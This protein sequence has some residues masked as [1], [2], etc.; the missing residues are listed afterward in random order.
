MGITFHPNGK[1]EGLN[2]ANYHESFTAGQIIQAGV[3]E[4]SPTFKATS[5]SFSANTT[6]TSAATYS[7]TGG[8]WT[9]T[10]KST[11]SK[12]IGLFS[13]HVD[14]YNH[15]S[16][17]PSIIAI[18]EGV[19]SRTAVFG[20]AYRHIRVS[21]DEPLSWI[22]GWVD[23]FSTQTNSAVPAYSVRCHSSGDGLGFGTRND[24]STRHWPCKVLYWEVAV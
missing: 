1:I 11:S 18:T 15:S 14:A 2:N 13:G 24:G 3:H 20:S 16:G 22:F 23:D 4:I 19:G 8:N 10:R 6:P 21:H 5:G 12:M 7:I 9:V 17:I